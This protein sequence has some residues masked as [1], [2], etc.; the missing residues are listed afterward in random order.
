M[1]QK[2]ALLAQDKVPRIGQA[3]K[4][5]IDANGDGDWKGIESGAEIWYNMRHES[6]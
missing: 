5:P 3:Q 2:L 6:V 1:T 4:R